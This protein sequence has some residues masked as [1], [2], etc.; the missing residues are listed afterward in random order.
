[1]VC[2]SEHVSNRPWV[3][4]DQKLVIVLLMQFIGSAASK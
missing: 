3:A 1:M 2:K 4:V